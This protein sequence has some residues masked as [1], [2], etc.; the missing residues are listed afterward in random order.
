MSYNEIVQ[1]KGLEQYQD[2]IFNKQEF[3]V[4]LCEW[5]PVGLQIVPVLW[6]KGIEALAGGGW[7]EELLW[8]ERPE[9]APL[10][11]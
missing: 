10:Q 7:R 5:R 1:E 8:V 11:R 2:N 6:R 3:C 9:E 4:L